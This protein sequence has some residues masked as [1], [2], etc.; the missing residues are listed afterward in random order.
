VKQGMKR[1]L[2]GVTALGLAAWLA[3]ALLDLPAA[4]VDLRPLLADAMPKSGVAHPVTAVLLNTRGYDTLLEIA[5]LLVA[6]IG[7]VI[8]MPDAAREKLA[9]VQAR[10]E[11]MTPALARFIV[12]L[13]I[14]FAIYV[15]WAGAH[16]P[17]GAFQ[18]AAILA[19]ALVLLHLAGLTPGWTRVSFRLR[20]GCVVGFAIFLVIAALPLH[21]G[22]LLQYPVA[23]AGLQILAIESGLS[24]SLA[25]VLASLFLLLADD[26]RGRS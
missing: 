25:L 4:I 7:V 6:L 11:T 21:G 19:A 16:R 20:A 15:L 22:L 24:I 12:P 8:A 2:V 17:G 13:A 3:G 23:S 5:V 26:G 9:P 1:L 10:Q 14:I 18:T